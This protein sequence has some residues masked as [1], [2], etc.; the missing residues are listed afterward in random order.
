[1]RSRTKFTLPLMAAAL[2][3]FSTEAAFAHRLNVFAYP[4]GQEICIEAS[5]AGGA[6]A[7]IADVKILDEKGQTILTAKTSEKGKVCVPTPAEFRPAPL[8]VIVNAG[9]GHQNK[10]TIEKSEFDGLTSSSDSLKNLSSDLRKNDAL[11]SEAGE[12]LF[13]QQELDEAIK[14]VRQDIEYTV[15]APLRKQLAEAQQPKT[16]FKDIIGGIGWLVGIAGLIA[17]FSSRRKQKA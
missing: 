3:L 8:T 7:R 17:W 6:P 1:M 12:K 5:F 13:T 10:W 4:T 11:S 2:T 15:V 9:E 16:T 14:A